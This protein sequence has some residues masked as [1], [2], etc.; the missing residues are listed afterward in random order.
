MRRQL[1]LTWLANV[2]GK[3]HLGTCLNVFI[4]KRTKQVLLALKDKN[5][6]TQYQV[7]KQISQEHNI[8]TSTIKAVLARLRKAGLVDYNGTVELT[9]LGLVLVNYLLGDE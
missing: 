1:S 5:G 9:E 6:L 7:V 3:G 4:S 2:G 8:A